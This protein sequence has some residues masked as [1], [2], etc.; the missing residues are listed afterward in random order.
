MKPNWI[1][2]LNLAEV[3]VD[4]AVALSCDVDPKTARSW[5]GEQW[6]HHTDSCARDQIVQRLLGQIPRPTEPRGK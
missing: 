6:R 3:Q 4:D 2:W 5:L 1:D